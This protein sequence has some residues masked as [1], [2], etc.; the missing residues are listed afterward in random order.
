LKVNKGK[1]TGTAAA[2]ATLLSPVFHLKPTPQHVFEIRLKVAKDTPLTVQPLDS[3]TSPLHTA[4]TLTVKKNRRAQT[5]RIVPF[6]QGAS[7][8]TQF[9][10]RLPFAGKFEIEWVKLL[11]M[12]SQPEPGTD[13][14][15][16]AGGKIIPLPPSP[17]PGPDWNFA[18]T[19]EGWTAPSGV[20]DFQQW[21]GVLYAKTRKD[22]P[23]L[24]LSPPLSLRADDLPWLQLRVKLRGKPKDRTL[25]F[26]WAA[27]DRSG[28]ASV[29]VPLK[30]GE[31]F[32][33]YSVPLAGDPD[34]KGAIAAVGLRLP[35][36][37]I[38]ELDYAR[39]GAGS[40]SKEPESPASD[41]NEIKPQ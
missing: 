6:W 27:P 14:P 37:S 32:E 20:D 35:P 30:G 16:D 12:A 8:I 22:E 21:L 39:L 26:F 4:Q 18:E 23:S 28:T 3:S 5:Y 11:D 1:L 38:V 2:E 17:A 41:R 25:I 34:W 33:E 31:E 29:S 24:L 9:Q 40:K 13:A 36:D 15:D 10:L 7:E 19:A